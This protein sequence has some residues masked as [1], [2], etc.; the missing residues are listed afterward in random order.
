MKRKANL[1]I[2]SIIFIIVILA[3]VIGAVFL[4]KSNIISDKISN[5]ELSSGTYE[6]LKEKQEVK[7]EIEDEEHKIVVDS[8]YEDSVDITIRS[9]PIEINLKVGETKKFDLDGDGKYDLEVKLMGIVGGVPNIFIRKINEVICDE[10]WN[11]ESWS[12]CNEQGKQIRVCTDLNSCGKT[13]NKPTIIQD[14][15]YVETCIENWDC[16][17][18]SGCVDGI[19]TRDCDD[20]NDCGK[21]DNKP[22]EKDGCVM[23]KINCGADWDCFINAAEECNL[24]EMENIQIMEIFGLIVTTTSHYELKGVEANICNLDLRIEKQTVEYTEE[25]KQFLIT[26]GASQE[27][28]TYVEQ[29]A[30]DEAKSLWGLNGSCDWERNDLTNMLNRWKVGTFNGRASCS[31]EGIEWGCILTGDY[32][33]AYRCEGN[34]FSSS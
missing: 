30:N 26:Q 17:A 18:W 19:K 1:V 22:D 9:E 2:I 29:I 25:F 8:V 10:D 24:A 5:E 16:T 34:Y 6:S 20:S 15:I 13:D 12:S 31:L 3:I 7:F 4:F 27:N 21:T 33:L 32:E 23:Q 28:I 11:C 14:C